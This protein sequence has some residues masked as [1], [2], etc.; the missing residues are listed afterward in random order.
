MA[1]AALGQLATEQDGAASSAIVP[2][3]A[4]E[5]AADSAG[6]GK[7]YGNGGNQAQSEDFVRSAKIG[8]MKIAHGHPLGPARHSVGVGAVA[9]IPRA[10]GAQ[11]SKVRLP[12]PPYPGW[13]C[14]L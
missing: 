8:P 13:P 1:T 10:P 2:R 12:T 4:S 14:G 3:A 7:L 6:F 11:R 5:E 9:P